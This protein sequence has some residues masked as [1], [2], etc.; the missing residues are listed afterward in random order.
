[1]ILLLFLPSFPVLVLF[2]FLLEYTVCMRH[3]L[4]CVDTLINGLKR[5]Y[6][7][8][9]DRLPPNQFFRVDEDKWTPIMA[10]VHI[11]LCKDAATALLP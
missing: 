9:K 6:T 11:V 7:R 10:A 3:G 1:M 8:E 5:E 2:V 4:V